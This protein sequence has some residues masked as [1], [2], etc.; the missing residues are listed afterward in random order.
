MFSEAVSGPLP[1]L[2][3]LKIHVVD[4]DPE[5]LEATNPPTLPLFSGAVNLKDLD[6]WADGL[7]RLNLFSFPNLTTFEFFATYRGEEA[8]PISQLLDFLE[9]TPTLRTVRITILKETSL[10]GVPLGRIV[11]LPNV[12]TLSVTED[13][14]VTRFRLTYHVPLQSSH[15]SPISKRPPTL[16]HKV[17]SL[18]QPHGTRSPLST[19]RVR[20]M[21]WRWTS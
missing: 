17:Y 12:E 8:F 19:W 20:L 16:F 2:T 18:P 9:A 6:L 10:E 5:D 1:L 3:S 15:R 4:S 7:P 13:D 11:V 21:R 14:P